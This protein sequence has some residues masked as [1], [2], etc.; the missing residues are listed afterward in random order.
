MVWAYVP[1][2][3]FEGYVN[4]LPATA[5][6]HDTGERVHDIAKWAQACGYWDADSP[7]L[8]ADITNANGLDAEEAEQLTDDIAAAGDQRQGRRQYVENAAQGW[9]QARHDL[10]DWLA[11]VPP[12]QRP[13][14]PAD[15]LLYLYEHERRI[16]ETLVPAIDFVFALADALLHELEQSEAFHPPE[17]EE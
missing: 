7:T 2:R 10:V 4:E 14:A 11:G 3:R 8:V 1:G 5:Q 9:A 16:T 12:Y 15:Q 17:D 13:T 6:R